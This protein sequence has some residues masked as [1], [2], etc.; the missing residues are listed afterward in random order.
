M[1]GLRRYFL[2]LKTNIIELRLIKMGNSCCAVED[3]AC[4]HIYIY[5]IYI[6]TYMHTYIT[7]IELGRFWVYM[8]HLQVMQRKPTFWLK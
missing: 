3:S 4:M 5:Y 6:H 2:L 7:C 1:T 8:Y